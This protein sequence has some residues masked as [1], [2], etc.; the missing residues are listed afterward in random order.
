[1]NPQSMKMISM[2]AP[3]MIQRWAR[4]V[5]R[6]NLFRIP[7]SGSITRL[8]AFS[9][10]QNRLGCDASAGFGLFGR[11]R[12]SGL[13]RKGS[14]G[15]AGTWKANRVV[16]SPRSNGD[17]GLDVLAFA[18]RNIFR[19]CQKKQLDPQH[20]TSEKL[21]TPACFLWT[22]RATCFKSLINAVTL[23]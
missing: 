20:P 1:M 17:S 8:T 21:K 7:L 18:L 3:S 16:G 13:V 4:P 10:H 15:H 14:L 11:K 6:R 22:K 23:N 2:A 5:E 19:E 9:S 12:S